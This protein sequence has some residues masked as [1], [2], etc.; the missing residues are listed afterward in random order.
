MRAIPCPIPIESLEHLVHSAKLTDVEIACMIPGGTAKRVRSWR[1]LY[2]VGT[3]P[4]WAR[5]NVIPIEG[6]L[7][8]LLVGSMLGDGRLVRQVNATYYSE[9][10]CEAQKPYLEWK[11]AMWG[12]WAGPIRDVPDKR[13]FSQVGMNTCAHESLNE[14]QGMFYPDRH[15]GWKRLLPCIVDMVDE[16]ALTV[17][18]M[19]DGNVGWWP[20]ITFGAD[21]TS[22][23]VAHA[24]F[25]KFQLKPRWQLRVR[26]T[27]AFIMEREDTAERFINLVK[28]HVPVCMGYKLGP[29]GFQ[30]PH[31][32]TRLKMVPE[33]IRQMA[34]ENVPIRVM[35]QRLGVGA[36]TLSRWLVKLG[37]E[38]VREIGRPHR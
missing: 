1:T 23:G 4:R 5:N 14:W 36:S 28:H 38:H 11:A 13:G 34:T 32:Q 18:Y 24:I 35:A 29:F 20:N 2:G 26:N 33:V 7:R 6:Q 27:G 22:R 16:F 19:D 31:Y 12:P 15:K 8:S 21:L 17:W 9:R 30:G 10:H 37:I 3:L 25:E